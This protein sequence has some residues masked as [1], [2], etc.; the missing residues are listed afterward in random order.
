MKATKTLCF[1]CTVLW[2]VFLQILLLERSKRS[3][4]ILNGNMLQQNGHIPTKLWTLEPWYGSL[5]VRKKYHCWY[6]S[7]V[8]S[9][10][11]GAYIKP[12][13]HTICVIAISYHNVQMRK[14]STYMSIIK[15]KHKNYCSSWY[16]SLTIICHTLFC[17]M[18]HECLA[19][20]MFSSIHN[21]Y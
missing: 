21:S 13:R 20:F 3:I 1:L 12:W 15:K 8:K 6:H 9:V 18:N 5:F 7:I 14:K 2:R 19:A 10:A 17:Y 4:P 16:Y 11:V